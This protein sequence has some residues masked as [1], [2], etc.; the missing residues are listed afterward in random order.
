MYALVN[1]QGSIRR[2]AA[3]S[4][5]ISGVVESANAPRAAAVKIRAALLGEPTGRGVL[6]S[7][8]PMVVRIAQAQ[9]PDEA[10]CD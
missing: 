2:R 8:S 7:S 1:G 4:M 6:K 5:V 9:I 10:A 3:T